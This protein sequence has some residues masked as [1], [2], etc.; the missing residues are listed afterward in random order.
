MDR[1]D[2]QAFEATICHFQ[3]IAKENRFAEN[4]SIAHDTDQCLVCRPDRCAGDPFTVYVDIIARC[5]P[6]RR[7]RLDPDLVAAIA[8]DAQWAGLSTSFT[9]QD[10]KDRRATAM[11]AFRLWVRNALETGLELLSVHSPTSLSF[12]LE[13]ARGIPQREAFVEG[14]IE[15]VMD[16]ILGENST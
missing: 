13:D 1:K 3:R 14:C 5:L 7:P 11:K 15:R 12:S 16:Q 10:L 8:E 6:V 2:T 4:A 9:V